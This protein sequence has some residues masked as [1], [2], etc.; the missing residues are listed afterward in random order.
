MDLNGVLWYTMKHL[1]WAA[2]RRELPYAG[3]RRDTICEMAKYACE[4]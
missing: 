1:I 4:I 2:C 3:L